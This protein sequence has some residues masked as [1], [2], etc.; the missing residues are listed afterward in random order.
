MALAARF[1]L[2][3]EREIASLDNKKISIAPQVQQFATGDLDETMTNLNHLPLG[4]GPE[5][6][7][8][9]MRV[10]ESKHTEPIFPDTISSVEIYDSNIAGE[11]EKCTKIMHANECE[12]GQGSPGRNGNKHSGSI[13]DGNVSSTSFEDERL[14]CFSV[15]SSQKLI[16]C[17]TQS[18]DRIGSST[19]CATPIDEFMNRYKTSCFEQRSFSELLCIAESSM[20]KDLDASMSHFGSYREQV[21]NASDPLLHEEWKLNLD[22]V[23]FVTYFF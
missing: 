22:K 16:D 1:P 21:R 10:E 11:K 20:F 4:K 15:I 12:T 6:D 8:S 3:R 17:A 7:H 5:I 2:N 18:V 14:L 23:K 13:V 19:E 9:S